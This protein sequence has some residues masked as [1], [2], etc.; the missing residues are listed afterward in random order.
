[1][2]D[3]RITDEAVENP[4]WCLQRGSLVEARSPSSPA[5]VHWVGRVVGYSDSKDM[6]L[7]LT[8][9]ER[10]IEWARADT[11]LAPQSVETVK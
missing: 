6:Y 3:P 7:I 8:P 2:S 11:R 1:V 10:L 4:P 5:V 9:S